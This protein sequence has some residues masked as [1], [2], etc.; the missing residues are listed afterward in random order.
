M[1]IGRVRFRISRIFG[2][3]ARRLAKCLEKCHCAIK[4]DAKAT[5]GEEWRRARGVIER[6]RHGLA[7]TWH[8]ESGASYHRRMF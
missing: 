2:G 7:L 3:V 6:T 1:E 8:R 5:H 4:S